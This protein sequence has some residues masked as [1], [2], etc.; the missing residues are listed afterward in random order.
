MP[1]I[2]QEAEDESENED[3]VKSIRRIWVTVKC[4]FIKYYYR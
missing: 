4:S 2:Q 1:E 3:S